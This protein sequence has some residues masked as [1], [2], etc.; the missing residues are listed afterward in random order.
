MISPEY[1]V[2][3]NVLAPIYEENKASL[4]KSDIWMDGKPKI[5]G[6]SFLKEENSNK[7]WEFTHRVLK[8]WI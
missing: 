8:E 2:S 3:H 5:V 1:A 4:G 6:K 7:L